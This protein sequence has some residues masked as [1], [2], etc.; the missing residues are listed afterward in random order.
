MPRPL[1]IYRLGFDSHKHPLA[2]AHT[3]LDEISHEVPPTNHLLS[4]VPSSRAAEQ[5][6]TL[7]GGELL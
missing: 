6:G 2:S 4:L 1:I 3:V 5:L 7:G